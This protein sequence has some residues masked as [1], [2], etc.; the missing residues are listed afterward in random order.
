M[1]RAWFR[2]LNI[3]QRISRSARSSSN[4]NRLGEDALAFFDQK[5]PSSD[6]YPFEVHFAP[7]LQNVPTGLE[8][9]HLVGRTWRQKPDAPFALAFGCNSWK[10][11]FIA[12]Y[13]PDMR[14]AFAPRKFMGIAARLATYRL[15][16]E[17]SCIYVW[18]YT[19]TS[20]WIS[21][22]ARGRNIPLIRIEDGF[23]RSADL[24][25]NHAT[26]YS[27]VFDR[28]GL[29]YNTS[30]PNDLADILSNYDFAGDGRLMEE[31][32]KA[33]D[34]IIEKRLSKY[35]PPEFHDTTRQFRI[36]SRKRVLVVGQVDSDAAVRLG[37]PDGWRMMDI[38]RL[39]K[40]ENPDAEVLYR[41]HPEIYRGYQKSK[42]R[43]G[44]IENFATIV[45]PEGP[46]LSLLESVDHV[47][48]L[49]SLSGL[50]A[51]V[52]GIKVTTLGT[53]FYA[54]WGLTDDR[55]QQPVRRA[56][57]VLELFA[58]AYLKYPR[59]LADL[60]DHWRGLRVSALRILADQM[61]DAVAPSKRAKE[62]ALPIVIS[63]K[64]WPRFLIADAKLDDAKLSQLIDCLAH[65]LRDN[66]SD[67]AQEAVVHA[68]LGKV[69]TMA[70]KD[71]VLGGISDILAPEVLNEVLVNLV[72]LESPQP[73]HWRHLSDLI[74]RVDPGDQSASAIKLLIKE[75]PAEVSD[76][77]AA[78]QVKTANQDNFL[79]F[80]ESRMAAQM[81]DAEYKKAAKTAKR[82]LLRKGLHLDALMNLA[83]I[84]TVRFDF[85]AV[86]MLASFLLMTADPRAVNKGPSME[87]DALEPADSSDLA[88]AVARYLAFK[89]DK[90]VNAVQALERYC[91]PGAIEDVRNDVL[92]TV[93][94]AN[95][96]NVAKVQSLLS[97]ELEE[98]ALEVAE[99]LVLSRPHLP[100]IAVVYA[101][102]LAANDRVAEARAVIRDVL[103][104]HPTSLV[105]REAM[106]LCILD[107]DYISGK[108]LLSEANS[109]R[110]D[111]G[112]MLPRK[113][114]FG[115][116]DIQAAFA[117]FKEFYLRS[118]MIRH[119]SKKYCVNPYDATPERTLFAAAIFGP[120]D[121]MRWAYIYKALPRV[122]PH[123][124]ISISCDPRLHALM[125]RSFPE[126]EF[127]PVKRIRN[128]DQY[129][130][131]DFNRVPSSR[132]VGVLDNVAIEAI[133]KADDF[134]LV[135]DLLSD[136]LQGYDSFSGETFFQPDPERVRYFRSRLPKGRP[137][138]GLSWRSSV[139]SHSRNEHYLTIEEL[140]PV[141]SI[142]GVQF[143][144][145]QYDECDDE[146]AWVEKH[147]PGKMIDFRELDQ[148][149]DFDGVSALMCSLD[150]IISSM[151]TPAELAGGLGC[152]TWLLSNSSELHW[153]KRPGTM[154][155]VW[156]DC[157][158]H[159]EGDI[160]SDKAS[161]VAVLTRELETWAGQFEKPVVELQGEAVH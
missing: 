106:R 79:A 90:I 141:L 71:R 146:L 85:A 131:A 139:R 95:S 99:Q 118:E 34:L 68:V 45:P 22:Y 123:S 59:Y 43:G 27:L 31:A 65:W 157:M 125:Q 119:F 92:A 103:D 152:P 40:L 4:L 1:R 14:V 83:E 29:Y 13:C 116:L 93:K 155:D 138:V 69:E 63:R 60:E 48:T 121:E 57:S 145:L 7:T 143:V 72:E 25:A 46:L 51:V 76:S 134:L 150:L 58:G 151:T 159:I 32:R 158:T 115:A 55:V 70:S 122:L 75:P 84:A 117:T 161:L 49:S 12:D 67:V 132:L 24:G 144:N 110:I 101:Q 44:Q 135:S 87:L 74:H 100:Q 21:N 20:S 129:E 16:P 52:R 89:P 137:L 94:L 3:V 23:L 97:L 26:P 61:H 124:R 53:P 33:L 133:D 140:A 5:I 96:L 154:I 153:R 35:N 66:P 102:A 64:T 62:Q 73:Y 37:N 149:N 15:T 36:K 38:V 114:N 28:K 98:E 113:I 126:I 9:F 30:E 19:D 108:Q 8:S 104:A 88:E 41:P 109:R 42:F 120:G 11:G 77:E 127:V 39:A 80:L 91:D 128:A 160:A 10:L 81:N 136:V 17:P 156:H 47:Y 148:F 54:G 111:I 142:P 18:G 78:A 2:T 147:F 50:E 130:I 56:L 107:N 112:D 105:Y 82:L 86:R 6:V